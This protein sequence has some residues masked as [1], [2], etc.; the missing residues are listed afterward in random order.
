LAA[1][2]TREVID[3]GGSLVLAGDVGT[4]K[5]H[6]AAAV[7]VNAKLSG[8]SALFWSVPS[9]LAALRSFGADG[10]YKRTLSAAC[11]CDVL[12]LDD[13]GVENVTDWAGE[14]LY[15]IVNERYANSRQT[16]ITTNIADPDSLVRHLGKNGLPVVSR[17]F[18]MGKW[19]EVRGDDYRM[20][21]RR[22]KLA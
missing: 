13:L 22:K 19:V 5:T 4:G 14:Q 1:E 17:L 12:V 16:I 7:V 10:K 20:R 9:L 21:K 11:R 6:L 3:G 18:G 15:I 2:M 8:R